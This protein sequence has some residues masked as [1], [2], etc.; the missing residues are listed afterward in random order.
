MNNIK[1]RMILSIE[2]VNSLYHDL[3]ADRKSTEGGGGATEI[4]SAGDSSSAERAAAEESDQQ[5]EFEQ[6]ERLVRSVCR[7]LESKGREFMNS[8]I[9]SEKSVV[10]GEEERTALSNQARRLQTLTEEVEKRDREL[11][12]REKELSEREMVAKRS[13]EECKTLTERLER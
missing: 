11:V 4:E 12:S 13:V 2:V 8:K 1:Q 10:R 3:S 6:Y 9:E 7:M 5:P